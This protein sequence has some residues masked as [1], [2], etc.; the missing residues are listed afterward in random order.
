MNKEKKVILYEWNP[1]TKEFWFLG[2]KIDY[3]H[4]PSE[5]REYLNNLVTKN[6]LYKHRL[7]IANEFIESRKEGM[8]PEHYDDLKYIINECDLESSW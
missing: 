5:W 1:I 8:I 2:E 6:K 4:N 3:I 7:E